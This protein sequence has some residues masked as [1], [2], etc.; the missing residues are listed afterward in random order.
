M[1]GPKCHVLVRT[2]VIF[3]FVIFNSSYIAGFSFILVPTWLLISVSVYHTFDFLPSSTPVYKHISGACQCPNVHSALMYAKL[4][5]T[6]KS[7]RVNERRT[8]ASP[9]HWNFCPVM[10]KIEYMYTTLRAC[11]LTVIHL[12]FWAYGSWDSLIPISMSPNCKLMTPKHY[13]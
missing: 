9:H 2:V 12:Q 13:F 3:R 6:D 1:V 10:T 11:T 8:D 4:L 7:S 5:F